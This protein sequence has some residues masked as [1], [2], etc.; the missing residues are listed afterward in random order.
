M[1]YFF[2]ECKQPADNKVT[3]QRRDQL[4]DTVVHCH[5]FFSLILICF[6]FILLSKRMKLNLTTYSNAL[7]KLS[8]K[9]G[10][11]N[12]RFFYTWE[13]FQYL[14]QTALLIGCCAGSQQ[15]CIQVLAFPWFTLWPRVD[16][17]KGGLYWA[18]EGVQMPY[19]LSHGE[20]THLYLI[21]SKIWSPGSNNLTIHFAVF[22]I[23]ISWFVE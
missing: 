14:D 19:I 12:I 17:I 4:P 9:V 21:F 22:W 5:L 13:S 3:W 7:E 6:Y 16:G 8:G 15:I 18:T 11:Y 20:C 2:R 1:D 23:F 10:G